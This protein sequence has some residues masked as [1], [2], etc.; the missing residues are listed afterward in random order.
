MAAFSLLI[1]LLL[2]VVGNEAA[3]APSSEC[4]YLL[5]YIGRGNLLPSLLPSVNSKCVTEYNSRVPSTYCVTECQSLYD[6]ISQCTTP[7]TA[8]NY[9]SIACNWQCTYLFST[10]RVPYDISWK[11]SNATYCSPTCQAAISTLEQKA[12]CCSVNSLDGPRVLCGEGPMP[13][14][15]TIFADHSK[16]THQINYRFRNGFLN[17][18]LNQSMISQQNQVHLICD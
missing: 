7:A 15:Y 12:G 10:N 1:G 6:L 4:A 17:Q 13:P 18:L 16:K 9:F 3:T 2:V 5:Q 14:C 11:C 8:P